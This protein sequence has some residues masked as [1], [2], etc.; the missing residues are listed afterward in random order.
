MTSLFSGIVKTIG[1]VLGVGGSS[2]QQAP[3]VIT[4]PPPSPTTTDQTANVQSQM[5]ELRKRQG[6]AANVLTGTS[7][8]NDTPTG[9]KTLLGQ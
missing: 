9:T 3:T 8:V 4:P 2:P 1:G 6:R 7:G 5:D